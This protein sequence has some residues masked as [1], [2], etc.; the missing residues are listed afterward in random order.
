MSLIE[1]FLFAVALSTFAFCVVGTAEQFNTRAISCDCGHSKTR[2]M[3]VI[4][5]QDAVETAR[6]GELLTENCP[7]CRDRRDNRRSATADPQSQ[8]GAHAR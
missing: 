7:T 8:R 2:R 1:G 6:I 5:V 3:L 4:S